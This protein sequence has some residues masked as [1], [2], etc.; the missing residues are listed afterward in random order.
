MSKIRKKIICRTETEKAT[1][2]DDDYATDIIWTTAVVDEEN[3]EIGNDA[4]AL[5]IAFAGVPLANDDPVDMLTDTV[6]SV[7]SYDEPDIILHDCTD[8]EVLF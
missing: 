4:S 3:S 5:T 8:D 7:F 6:A 1:K 2:D